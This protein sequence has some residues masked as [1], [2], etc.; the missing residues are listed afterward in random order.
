MTS[1]GRRSMAMTDK[2]DAEIDR[3]FEHELMPL[4]ERAKAKGVRL[5]QTQRLPELPS[6]YVRREHRSM[7][8][9]DFDDGGCRSANSVEQDLRALWESDREIGLA[10]L[11]P[12]LA[13]LAKN[14][15]AVEKEADDVSNFIYMMY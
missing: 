10:A 13:R 4:A 6:Y 15:R 3:F 2:F 8:K 12:S 9:A 14:L 11:A 7:S 5:L 1:A